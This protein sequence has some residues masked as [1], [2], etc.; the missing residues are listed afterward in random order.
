MQ[1]MKG[2]NELQFVSWGEFRQMTPPILGLEI[3]RMGVVL[4]SL[5]KGTAPY[6][7]VVRAR[8]ELGKFVSCI[9]K[10]EKDAVDEKCA[11][12]LRAAIMSLANGLAHIDAE[13]RPVCSYILDRLEYVHNRMRLI[14]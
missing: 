1:A 13:L 3:T 7:D 2:W 4:R 5:T 11:T 8:F 10:C 9:Q 6:N 12:C 14:Y